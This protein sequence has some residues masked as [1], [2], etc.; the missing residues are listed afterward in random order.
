MTYTIVIKLGTSSLCDEVTKEPRIGNMARIAEVA[1]K[2]RRD[3]H[4]VIIVSSGGIAAG[5]RLL[6]LD[7]RPKHLAQT[8]A[9]A[10][11]GQ[12]SLIGQWE[13]LFR[14]L[15]QPI[16]QILLTRNDISDRTQ[17]L[18]AANTINE[19]VNMGA[20]PIV[21]ENDTLSVYEIRFGDN[22]SLSAIAAGMVQADYLFLM[23]DVDCLYTHNPRLE[24][25]LAKPVLIVKDFTALHVDVSTKGSA[26]GTGGMTTKII[27]ARLA[28]SAGVS[29]VICKSFT[30]ENVFSIVKYIQTHEDDPRLLD[31]TA[32]ISDEEMAIMQQQ[33]LEQLVMANVPLHTRFIPRKDPI[34]S[35]QFWLLHGLTPQGRLFIDEGAY[36][37]VTR[38]NRAGLFPVGVI[39]VEGMF[40]SSECVDIVVGFRREDGTLDETKPRELIGRALVNYASAEID[41]I[42]GLHSHDIEEQLGYADSEYVAFRDNMGFFKRCD[43]HPSCHEQYIPE[44]II[45]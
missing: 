18:N 28:T 3:G 25:E 10:A 14:Q 21:N 1:V 36:M 7:G 9:I 44:P 29:V 13:T 37:A 22:D 15:G 17:Y 41:R 24:P 43:V 32:H 40:H 4:R 19:L 39:K 6:K 16:G 12:A 26:V 31:H 23:T 5:L 20:I 38:H 30:P 45:S 33:E 35:R 11:I 42:K 27:A 34:K 2:L 8:Q